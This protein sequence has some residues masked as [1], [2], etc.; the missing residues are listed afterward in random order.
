MS[1]ASWDWWLLLDRAADIVTILGITTLAF[2]YKQL[3]RKLFARRIIQTRILPID[4]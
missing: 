3:V 2:S 1:A 4:K